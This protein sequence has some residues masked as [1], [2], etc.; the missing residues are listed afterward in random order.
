MVSLTTGSLSSMQI[1]GFM[2]AGIFAYVVNVHREHDKRHREHD[3][4]LEELEKKFDRRTE[5][6]HQESDGRT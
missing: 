3:E 1:L 4:R 6:N 2:V 5:E